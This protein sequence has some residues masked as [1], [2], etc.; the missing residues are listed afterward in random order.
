MNFFKFNF[1]KIQLKLMNCS[2]IFVVIIT[3][4]YLLLLFCSDIIVLMEDFNNFYITDYFLIYSKR[5]VSIFFL[6]FLLSCYFFNNTIKVNRDIFSFEF[7]FL[8]IMIVL[9][10]MLMLSSNNLVYLYLVLELQALTTYAFCCLSFKN[11][12]FSEA[13]LKYF[14]TGGVGSVFFLV[15]TLLLY[16]ILG[17]LTFSDFFVFYIFEF[18]FVDNLKL[19]IGFLFIIC[20]FFFKLGFFPF[21][22]WVIDVYSGFS[23]IFL[24]FLLT[25]PK[26]GFLFFLVHFFQQFF[27]FFNLLN[28]F[29]FFIGIFSIIVGSINALSQYNISKFI[30]YSSLSNSGFLLILLLLN[31]NCSILVF[32]FYFL[33]Y[34]VGLFGFFF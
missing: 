34:I 24:F 8:L 2:L 27:L 7:S 15:G 29:I 21:Y 14:I 16:S 22:F 30:V 1:D 17:S 28:D 32:S 4:W 26:M 10:I 20:Y 18:D 12:F 25:I 5:L 31:N 9:A 23:T 3:C 13:S 11:R 6:L 33:S 19:Q